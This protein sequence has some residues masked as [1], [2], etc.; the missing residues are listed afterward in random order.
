MSQPQETPSV[1]KQQLEQG[2]ANAK[3]FGGRSGQ[4]AEA[5]LTDMLS[6]HNR[7]GQLTIG[8]TRYALSLF[9]QVD[10]EALKKQQ[11]QNKAW[12]QELLADKQLQAKVSAVAEYYLKAGYYTK[13]AQRCIRWLKIQNHHI[14]KGM[15]MTSESYESLRLPPKFSVMKMINNPYAEKVID[16]VTSEPIWKVGDLVC[17]RATASGRFHL[18][19]GDGEYWRHA[20]DGVYTIIQV[21]SRPIDK[22]I[23]YKLKRGGARYYRLLMLGSTRQID[24]METDLKKVQKKLIS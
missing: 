23:T 1:S 16:S 9:A 10:P 19:S 2:I 12:E 4:R 3:A 5:V 22:A 6:Y 14:L 13:T 15:D 7:K 24:V 20:G 11:E 8:Q 18:V 21:D 17:C